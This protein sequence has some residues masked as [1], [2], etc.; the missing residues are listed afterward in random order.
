[1]YIAC[2]SDMEAFQRNLQPFKFLHLHL[3]RKSKSIEAPDIGFYTANI[4]MPFQALI[5]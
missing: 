5:I 2:P 1:M 3:Y 4:Q